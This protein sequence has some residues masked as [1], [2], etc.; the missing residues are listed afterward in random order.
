MNTPTTN[1]T[2][3]A[4]RRRARAH[5]PPALPKGAAAASAPAPPL[6]RGCFELR[7]RIMRAGMIQACGWGGWGRWAVQGW[8]RP[9]AHL[10]THPA[11]PGR[12]SGNQSPRGEGSL[13][14][15]ARRA[16]APSPPSRRPARGPPRFRAGST[17]WH[18]PCRSAPASW[19]ASGRCCRTAPRGPRPAPV[20]KAG[21]RR[22]FIPR[23]DSTAA[24]PISARSLGIGQPMSRRQHGGQKQRQCVH[25]PPLGAGPHPSIK[26]PKRPQKPRRPPRPGR[27]SAG[28]AAAGTTPRG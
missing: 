17:R 23:P 3:A 7:A 9:P 15:A 18:R 5:R 13:P 27:A 20:T 1:M 6:P 21:W 16:P 14:R 24:V 25:R 26:F 2:N 10:A 11:G 8:G 22:A 12:T 19:P 4:P 28:R